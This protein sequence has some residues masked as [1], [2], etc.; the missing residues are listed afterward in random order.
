MLKHDARLGLVEH[1]AVPCE[2]GRLFLK[3]AMTSGLMSG[4]LVTDLF[5]RL[6]PLLDGS[7][8]FE[9]IAVR[10]SGSFERRQL[11]AALDFLFQKGLVREIEE[12]PEQLSND[13]LKRHESMVRYFSRYGSRYTTL[14]ALKKPNVAIIDPGPFPPALASALVPLGVSQ[15]T[16]IA[17][18]EV[19]PLEVQQS[20]YYHPRDE[21][22]NRI[23]VW[24]ERI[25]AARPELN[26]NVI[27][28]KVSEVSNWRNFLTA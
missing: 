7:N 15:I 2:D 22:C 18:P 12:P 27:S 24:R 10:M 13:D 28:T 8:R 6:F 9:D 11:S 4:R 21:N 1:Y 17:S 23:S 20:R 3:T 14:V 25:T 26:L 16:L 5:P 19:Q